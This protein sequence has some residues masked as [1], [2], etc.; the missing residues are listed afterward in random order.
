MAGMYQ[1]PVIPSAAPSRA[2]ADEDKSRDLLLAV[3]RK[4]DV[5]VRRSR[6]S[7]TTPG[8]KRFYDPFVVVPAIFCALE[9]MKA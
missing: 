7:Q 3:S 5:C 9:R 8:T 2:R 1:Q 4:S 6:L